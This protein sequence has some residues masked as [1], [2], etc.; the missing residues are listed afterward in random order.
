M[1]KNI[2][3]VCALALA[4]LMI[5]TT[6][7]AQ[8]ADLEVTFDQK[9]VKFKNLT[10]VS[11]DSIVDA[12]VNDGR[13]TTLVAAL[14]ATGLDTVLDSRGSFTVLAPTDGAFAKLGSD[15]I[16]ALLNDLPT[17][18]NILLYH[19][20]AGE[21][22]AS[23]VVTLNKAGTVLGEKVTIT[24]KKNGTVFINDSK[25]IITDIQTANGIIH[26]LDT[27][28]LPS[29]AAEQAG[30]P[31]SLS[32]RVANNSDEAER[33][34][35][36]QIFEGDNREK[37][38]Y[39][40]RIVRLKGNGWRTVDFHWFPTTDG[41]RLLTAA[42]DPINL[43]AESDEDNNTAERTI[44]VDPVHGRD[45]TVGDVKVT[46]AYDYLD[47]QYARVQF[48]IYNVGRKNATEVDYMVYLTNSDKRVDNG[49]VLVAMG[50]ADRIQRRG[51][52]VEF[53][54]LVDISGLRN[55]NTFYF[56]AEVDKDNTIAEFDE[57][58]NA[59]VKTYKKRALSQEMLDIV[60]TAISAD[61][62]NTLVAAVQAAGLVDTLR[63][64]SE[65]YTV[66]APTDAA[67]AALGSDT[68]NALLADPDALG[69]ILL[70]HVVP[71]RFG[72]MAVLG[73]SAF[74]MANG[75]WAS[76]SL[77]NGLPFINDAQIVITDIYCGNGII[78]VID[79]VIIPPAQ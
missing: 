51:G 73:T 33:D 64:R 53:D 41:E 74:T 32:V 34:V 10:P 70:Y 45:L 67:F 26:V 19:V 36:L 24:V 30:L 79:A 76:I 21:V 60:E 20:I 56:W 5:M 75:G 6:A 35:L 49:A 13:F 8:T 2:L 7:T 15:T 50:T 46:R 4:S 37:M 68:I 57:T 42:V 3:T 66:F 72:S 31:V 14:Q 22:P 65:N 40:E 61:D 43:I 55:Q 78:H 29:D 23:T 38:V 39:Q 28:L 18:T 16:N 48:R 58:N 69:N 27:V 1:K 44:S 54:L 59:L 11:G 12:A 47:K 9:P 52:Y 63:D 17:L 77:M 71:G 25:V 62:F